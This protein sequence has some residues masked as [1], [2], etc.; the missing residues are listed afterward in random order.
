V[1]MKKTKE[2]HKAKSGLQNSPIPS[3]G[4]PSSTRYDGLAVG[5][6]A[7]A[8]ALLYFQTSGYPF[9]FDDFFNIVD[10]PYIRN[11]GDVSL[12]LKG[13]ELRTNWFRA[14]PALS[15]AINYHFHGLEV[16]GYHLVNLLLH[17]GSGILVYFISKHLFVLDLR[18]DRALQEDETGFF[19][20]H[21]TPLFSLFVAL[22]FVAHPLQTNT[23]TYIVER[24]EGMAAFFYLLGLF[25]FMKGSFSRGGSKAVYLS[26][27]GVVFFF[28]VLSKEIGFTLPIVLILF[29]LLFVC[30]GKEAMK[31]RL[32]IYGAVGLLL[33][34]YLLFFLRGGL[35]AL[36]FR[37]N[38]VWTPWENLLT[39][40][41]VLIRYIGLLFLPWPG[42]MNIDHDI[43]VSRSLFE[44]PTFMSMATILFLFLLA[45]YLA[46]KK[47]RLISFGIFSFFI[48]LAPTSSVIPIW[49]TM[50]EYRLYLPVFSFGLILTVLADSLY[51]FLVRRHSERF[52]RRVVA[53]IAILVLALYSLFT[54]QRN[55][56]FRED[57]T[58]WEDAVR[59]SPDKARVHLGLGMALLK[60][61]RLEEARDV[62]KT[63]LGKY[64]KNFVLVYYGLGQVYRDLG[65]DEK[66]IFHFEKYLRE[67]PDDQRAYNELG[68]IYLRTGALEKALPCFQRALGIDPG[69]A[70]AHASLGD[71]YV[72]RGVLDDAIAQYKKAIRIDPG[73]TMARIRLGE[74]Y[75][76]KGMPEEAR[77]EM[78]EAM[79]ADPGQPEAYAFLGAFYLQEGRLEEAFQF[80]KKALTV[81]PRDPEVY[82]NLGVGYRKKGLID[83]AIVHYQ[84]AIEIDPNL[85]DPHVNLGEA[86]LAKKRSEEALSEFNKAISINPQKAEPYNNLGVVSLERKRLDDAVSYFQKAVS[87]NPKYGEA[88]FNLAVAYY[89]KK[90]LDKARDYSKRALML[91]YRV[92]PKLLGLLLKSVP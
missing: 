86:Y 85:F 28:A 29:D 73:L 39:Q 75:L 68:S 13:L 79:A 45:V 66:A 10:N 27:T 41:N 72:R 57:I 87:L 23:V 22:I 47:K 78:K 16:F 46:K 80:L 20:R 24:N 2:Q 43:R 18:S 25:L 92:D 61:N 62:L 54:V 60:L 40:A 82:N 12:F 15:F 50:V 55:Y 69:Y 77:A 89:Y 38:H 1:P 71:L 14:L 21:G 70:P 42:W 32:K 81:R 33:A 65:D 44:F 52:G 6:I 37:Q 51:Q 36:L 3:G 83:E 53:T 67:S 74:A 11:L 26:G 90:D 34:I 48:I 19:N 30:Q 17:A 59:K 63:A 8:A 4:A 49:D 58:L 76:K 5:M 88:Y 64:P 7:F 91:G 9:H 56:V 31:K 84:K 35:Y